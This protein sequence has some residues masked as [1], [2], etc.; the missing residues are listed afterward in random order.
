M[1]FGTGKSAAGAFF[2]RRRKRIIAVS[3]TGALCASVA[4]AAWLTDSQGP[5]GGKAGTLQK[6]KVEAGSAPSGAAGCVP[7]AACDGY[8][9]LTND[10]GNG[11]VSV[12]SLDRVTSGDP[13]YDVSMFTTSNPTGCPVSNFSVMPKTGGSLTPI[14]IGQ[15]GTG[16][17]TTDAT[18]PGLFQLAANA[19]NACQGV[20]FTLEV[21]ATVQA[22]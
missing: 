22:G 17:S 14:P 3:V 5:A 18:V 7:G 6:I 12:I 4:M 20:T 21:N 1:T 8:L 11:P 9:H 15:G 16:E 10:P 13:G 2:A 19:P